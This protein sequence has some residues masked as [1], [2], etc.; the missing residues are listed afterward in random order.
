MKSFI[1][2]QLIKLEAYVMNTFVIRWLCRKIKM[3]KLIAFDKKNIC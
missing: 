3:D 1:F 2:S